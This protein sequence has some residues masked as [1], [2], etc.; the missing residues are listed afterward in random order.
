MSQ[1]IDDELKRYGIGLRVGLKCI[2]DRKLLTL[3][4]PFIVGFCVLYIIML[5]LTNN[6]NLIL[7]KKFS[8]NI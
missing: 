2:I 3:I 8:M 7:R 1:L 6:L 4:F 5:Y